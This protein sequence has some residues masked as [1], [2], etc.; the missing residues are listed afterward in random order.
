M[1]SHSLSTIVY[2]QGY[3]GDFIEEITEPITVDEETMTDE[4]M[5]AASNENEHRTETRQMWK[6]LSEGLTELRRENASLE[7]KLA[8]IDLAR[9]TET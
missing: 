6:I 3:L 1:K 7:N 4:Q 5:V 2:A 8:L 9:N